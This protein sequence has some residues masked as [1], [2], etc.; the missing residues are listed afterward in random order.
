MTGAIG[1]SYF[2]SASGL[3]LCLTAT[4]AQAQVAP[5]GAPPAAADEVPN[6]GEIVVT[7]SKRE[8]RLRDVPSAITVLG[9]DTIDRPGVQSIRDY[10]TLTP[11]LTVQDDGT[12]GSGKVYIRG[13]QTGTPQQSA[14]TGIHLDDVDR[15]DVV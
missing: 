5:D 1:K 13:L 2:L 3:A 15:K 12:P 10:A 9:G 7:A 14:T 6:N 8:E 11:G 4:Q